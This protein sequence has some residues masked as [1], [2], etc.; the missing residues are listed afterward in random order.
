MSCDDVLPCS[1]FF[2]AQRCPLFVPTD[3]VPPHFVLPSSAHTLCPHT[4]CSPAAL[5]ADVD[6]FKDQL[7]LIITQKTM[8]PS[9]TL[10]K[11]HFPLRSDVDIFK[12][13]AAA[14]ASVVAHAHP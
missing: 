10:H 5:G 9:S 1:A 7:S 8:I 12:R 6:I 11:K 2:A 14:S 4:F 13:E 3:F